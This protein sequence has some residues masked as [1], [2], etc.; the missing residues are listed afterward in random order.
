M[1][2]SWMG[3][4]FESSSEGNRRDGSHG[5]KKKRKK[6]KTKEFR[7]GKKILR[8][9]PLTHQIKSKPHTHKTIASA[10]SSQFIFII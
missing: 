9:Y 1:T 4:K 5:R 10:C 2:F 6:K 8:L 3:F 7:E